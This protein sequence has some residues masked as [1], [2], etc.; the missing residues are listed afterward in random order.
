[1]SGKKT[2]SPRNPYAPAAKQRTGA[3]AMHDR[4]A[5]RGGARNESR[6]DVEA[7]EQE[8]ENAADG[9]EEDS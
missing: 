2:P 6:E 5:P 9:N 1:M 3:G 8:A 4:R 7:W